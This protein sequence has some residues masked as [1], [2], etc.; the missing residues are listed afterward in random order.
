M[1]N[2][3]FDMAG[4]RKAGYNDDQIA[5]ALSQQAG[6]DSK[7]ARAAG[8]SSKDIILYLRSAGQQPETITPDDP[9][10]TQAAIIGAGR[11]YDRIGK[12]MQ[13]IWY[14]VTGNDKA[15]ENLKRDAEFDDKAYQVLQDQHPVATAVGESAP[16]MVIP[17]GGTAGLLR[18]GVKLAASAAIPAALEY[19]TPEERLKKA[20]ISGVGAGVGGV[21]VPKL[22]GAA[23]NVTKAGA[24]G[25]AGEIT[26]AAVALA[27]KAKG[28]G[29]PVNL[30]QLGDSKFL[31]TLA[32]TLE[33]MP[34]TGA[35]Q[36]ASEQRAKFTR[37]VSNTF[38][39]D[40]DKITPEVYASAKQ[41][42]QQAFNDL[43]GR[44]NLNVT[45][46]LTAQLNTILKQAEATG[47]DDTIRAIKNIISR[48][49]NQA[50]TKGGN[51]PAQVSNLV[52]ANGAPIVKVAASST[53]EVTKIPGAAYASIDSELGN[54]IKAGGEKGLY[55]KQLQSII[56]G[57]MDESISEADKAAWDTA[58]TQY[59]NLKAVRNIVARDGGD[60]NIPPVQ[61]MS[62]LNNTEA[63]KEAMALG[64]RGALGELG[65]IG[66]QFVRDTVPNSGTAQRAV[67]MGLIGGGGFAFGATPEEVAGMLAGGATAGR[68]INK[69]L[70]NPN[71]VARLSQR[72]LTVAELLKL[73]PATIT[74]IVGG[75]S[76]MTTAKQFQQENK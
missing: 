66:K 46:E 74:Q 75:A 38:G 19:G 1:G 42:L 4:A 56:R 8:H 49:T 26:P 65:Q 11:T 33:Q 24:R 23:Y 9:G 25:L 6:F 57:G 70:T 16:S 54:I 55:A 30:A 50:E 72:G 32:S 43:T 18:T 10:A 17:V 63:G 39:E 7:A 76:G 22:A 58:R 51:V 67:A 62:S 64:S 69:V 20:A 40:T 52:D 45:P 15:L 59:K 14:N 61:L 44:N 5:D 13:Q 60:G 2:L 3:K 35:A 68:L 36:K 34:F 47:S 41:R 27:E 48:T 28:Y 73:P 29:I 12:G 71:M 21:V 31:K 53:P 37:A